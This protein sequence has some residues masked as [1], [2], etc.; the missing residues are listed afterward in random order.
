MHARHSSR[1]TS[2]SAPP[3]PTRYDGALFALIRTGQKKKRPTIFDYGALALVLRAGVEPAQ[4]SLSVFET[5]AS[6]D[7]AIW[8]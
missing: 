4:V 3:S 6:T 1:P 2:K 8:A 5:D 7:S